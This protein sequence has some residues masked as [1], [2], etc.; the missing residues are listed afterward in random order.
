[1]TEPTHDASPQR[2]RRFERIDI[3]PGSELLVLD[4]EG[5][6]MGALR[7]LGRGGFM[8]ETDEAY[9]MESEVAEFI[10]H[11]AEED[12]RLAIKARLRYFDQRFAGFEF[13]ELDADAAVDLGI[14]IGK[15]YEA[16]Q[17]E[18]NG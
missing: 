2:Q 3:P 12:I 7:Q 17:R 11:E 4:P 16:H 1:M 9:L 5:K 14:I 13:V 6:K 18:R 10:L 8:M 15:Y